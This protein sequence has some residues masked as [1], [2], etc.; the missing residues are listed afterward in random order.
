MAGG[1]GWF[2][3]FNCGVFVPTSA[4]LN[5]ACFSGAKD[6]NLTNAGTTHLS[7]RQTLTGQNDRLNNTQK[8]AYFDL[9]WQGKGDLKI[10]NQLFYD[11]GK[12]L[13]EN[14][15]GFSQAFNSYVIEDKIVASDTFGD[16]LRQD[17]AAAS[18]SVRYTHFHF[19]DDYGVELWNRPDITV[20]YTPQS[21][22]LLST[23]CDCN[24]SD[25]VYGHYTD[26]GIAGLVD[27]DPSS[28]SISSA[29][30]GMTA[31]TRESTALLEI[32]AGRHQ[33]QCGANYGTTGTAT[34]KGTEGGVSWSASISYKPPI[35]LIPY[36]TA[37]RQNSVVAGEGSELYLSNILSGNVLGKS[38]LLEA[39]PKG[40]FLDKKLLR[41]RL[42]L[43]AEAHAGGRRKLADQP[44]FAEQGRGGRN[45]LGGGSP[46]AGDGR[47]PSGS[48]QSGR[49]QRRDLANYFHAPRHR[50]PLLP[51]AWARPATSPGSSHW[52]VRGG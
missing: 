47:H 30:S 46:P 37:S 14:A 3:S 41:R 48:D 11:G 38:N 42:G 15:Y 49:A 29:A 16:L 4:G 28:A 34:A 1:L 2:G 52:R 51:A 12:N 10:K 25:Y 35:G 13:N 5:S 27:V 26:Y 40:E 24:Y 9:T 7:A 17:L 50:P 31:C 18:P 21:T 8:T 32:R 22:R 6:M 36:F 19:A 33:R 45:P 20:G 43:Q 39:G 44:D 23:Q